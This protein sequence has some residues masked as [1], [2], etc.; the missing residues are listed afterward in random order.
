MKR[1]TSETTT[2]VS[3]RTSDAKRQHLDVESQHLEVDIAGLFSAIKNFYSE[4]PYLS[5][6]ILLLSMVCRAG[7][8]YFGGIFLYKQVRLK[9]LFIFHVEDWQ[10]GYKVSY[11]WRTFY[12]HRLVPDLVYYI[13]SFSHSPKRIDM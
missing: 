4:H 9:A 2:L 12:P 7:R 5:H 11:N 10:K 13:W 6:S 1:K 3:Y 8:A